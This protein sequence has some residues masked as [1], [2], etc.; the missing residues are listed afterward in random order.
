VWKDF[1]LIEDNTFT[2]SG[3]TPGETY[4]I[5]VAAQNIHGVGE[6][7]ENLLVIAG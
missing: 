5:A 3:L 6:Q 4:L 7:S 1:A 2:L